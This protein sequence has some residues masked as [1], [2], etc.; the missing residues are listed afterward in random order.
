MPEPESPQQAR[1]RLARQIA[2]VG[3]VLPG[4]VVTRFTRCG[5]ANCR[6][7]ADPPEPHGPYLQWTRKVDGR[8]RSRT[9]SPAQH[10]RYQPWFDNARRLRLLVAELEALSMQ[11]AEDAEGWS[12]T[13]NSR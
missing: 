6:C 5:K 8:T 11:T 4:S 2:E 3:F 12:D 13:D 10:E 9:L 7:Q 1:E